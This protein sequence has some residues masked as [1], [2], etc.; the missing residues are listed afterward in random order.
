MTGSPKTIPM[1]DGEVPARVC[2]EPELA[3]LSHE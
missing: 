3:E 2:A 1:T